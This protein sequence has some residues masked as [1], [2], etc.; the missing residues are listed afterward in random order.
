[1]VNFLLVPSSCVASAL[2]CVCVS[3]GEERKSFTI[4]AMMWRKK[5]DGEQFE[6]MEK[7]L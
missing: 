5:K 1:M 2:V 4:A 7:A 6:Q 3:V